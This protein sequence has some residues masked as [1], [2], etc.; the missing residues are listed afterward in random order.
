[1]HFALRP[2][3]YIIISKRLFILI[4]AIKHKINYPLSFHF[5]PQNGF[6]PQK[7][8]PM[9]IM[10]RN[11]DK[12]SSLPSQNHPNP[13]RR[14]DSQSDLDPPEAFSTRNFEFKVKVTFG[15]SIKTNIGTK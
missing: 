11:E 1:M 3:I 5:F 6:T 13:I 15:K 12:R 8:Q 10:F 14:S 7:K 2:Y 9:A 4:N